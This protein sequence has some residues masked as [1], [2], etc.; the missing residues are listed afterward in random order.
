M[1]L[2]I[3]SIKCWND[4]SPVLASQYGV[5]W[6][7][8]SKTGLN[9]LPQS[10]V[11]RDAVYPQTTSLGIYNY[12]TVLFLEL[13][14]LIDLITDC[15]AC[16]IGSSQPL[17]HCFHV[18]TTHFLWN[19]VS[20]SPPPCPVSLRWRRQAHN[21]DPVPHFTHSILHLAA[22]GLSLKSK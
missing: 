3:W 20:V 17:L 15:S 1:Y 13:Q 9:P 14:I 21:R 5:Q 8:S 2:K 6:A 18:R 10:V 22:N 16:W 4:L 11:T 19:P 12:I 7:Q